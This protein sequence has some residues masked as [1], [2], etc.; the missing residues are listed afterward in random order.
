MEAG[1]DETLPFWQVNLPPHLREA[2]CPKYLADLSEK[3]KG[4]IGTKDEDFEYMQWP[5]VK[6]LIRKCFS[7]LDLKMAS[8]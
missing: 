4:I 2:E 3:D 8:C 5:R 1:I 6:Q 7:G